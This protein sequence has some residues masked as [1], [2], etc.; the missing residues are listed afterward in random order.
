MKSKTTDDRCQHV[1]GKKL[2]KN[3]KAKN[4]RD[5]DIG[6]RKV[7]YGSVLGG[8]AKV[9]NVDLE[10]LKDQHIVMKQ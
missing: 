9:S 1:L 7:G 5:E 6:T 3:A 2:D 10:M 4:E 8:Q